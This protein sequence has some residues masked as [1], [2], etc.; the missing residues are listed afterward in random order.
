MR[1]LIAVKA[2]T[3]A[4]RRLK[5]GDGFIARSDRDAK[6]LL[7]LKKAKA[8]PG[9]DLQKRKAAEDTEDFDLEYLRASYLE[10]KGEE[11]D[12]R[13]GVVRLKRELGIED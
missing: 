13:W 11:P 6:V 9:V 7:A 10:Q 2:L 12:K 1:N 5:A 8:A 3:Y 4:T